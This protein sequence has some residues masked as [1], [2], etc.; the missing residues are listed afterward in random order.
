MVMWMLSARQVR[1]IAAA[2]VAVVAAG[3]SACGGSDGEEVAKLARATV[4]AEARVTSG[5]KPT[6]V[7]AADPLSAH[8]QATLERDA[9][10]LRQLYRN[11]NRTRQRLTFTSA[12]TSIDGSLGT[13]K[14]EA[15]LQQRTQSG[16]PDGESRETYVVS[17]R[18]TASGWTV[19]RIRNPSEFGP[20]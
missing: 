17:L 4:A 6:A 5:E 1:C 16:R 14:L 18:R 20:G 7:L 10:Y 3:Q 12:T 11:L 8:Y 9:P 19:T 13:V 15:L 2:S